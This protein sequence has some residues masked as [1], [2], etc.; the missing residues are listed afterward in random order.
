MYLPQRFPNTGNS[1]SFKKKERKKERQKDR[2]K[3]RKKDRK[4]ERKKERKKDRK[5]ERKKGGRKEERKERG[6]LNVHQ[7]TRPERPPH[8]AAW[9]AGG[10]NVHTPRLDALRYSVCKP[11]RFGSIRAA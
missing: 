2:K 3:E 11:F 6:G 4:T 9:M 1:L 10:L 5:K 8:R 7:P